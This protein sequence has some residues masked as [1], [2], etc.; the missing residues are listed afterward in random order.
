MKN[1]QIVSQSLHNLPSAYITE[2]TFMHNFSSAAE[3][4]T[5]WSSHVKSAS[6]LAYANC[7]FRTTAWQSSHQRSPIWSCTATNRCLRWRRIPGCNR[8]SNSTCLVSVTFSI[9]SRQKHIECEFDEFDYRIWM[10]NL[11]HFS[12]YNR[13]VT[14]GGKS[15]AIPPRAD[16]TKKLSRARS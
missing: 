7:T 6:W 8:S 13:H 3:I 14:G 11:W 5:C 12:L 2:T 16:K 15:N 1:L 9:T 10:I 4:M